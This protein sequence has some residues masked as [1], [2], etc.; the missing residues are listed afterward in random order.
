MP[1]KQ[2]AFKMN[3]KEFFI[4]KDYDSSSK[5][6]MEKNDQLLFL[7]KETDF[8]VKNGFSDGWTELLMMI[9]L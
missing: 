7:C 6:T 9:N 2:I 4:K 1:L 5:M 3:Q 8:R